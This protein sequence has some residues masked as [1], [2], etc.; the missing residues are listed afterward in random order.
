MAKTDIPPF[1]TPK[2][3]L[4]LTEARA[5]VLNAIQ[6]FSEDEQ[7]DILRELS[8]ELAKDQ[9]NRLEACVEAMTPKKWGF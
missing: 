3:R 4:A 2:R 1:R 8:L 6:N 9:I 5:G 7:I